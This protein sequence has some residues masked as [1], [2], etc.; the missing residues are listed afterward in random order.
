M[1]PSGVCVGSAAAVVVGV[2]FVVSV[3]AVAFVVNSFGVELIE[4][5]G[6]VV[7]ALELEAWVSFALSVHASACLHPLKCLPLFDSVVQL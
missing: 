2:A 1:S 5:V 3:D 7:A 4:F 6:D